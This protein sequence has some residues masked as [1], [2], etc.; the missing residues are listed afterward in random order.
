VPVKVVVVDYGSNPRHL[1]QIRTLTQPDWIRLI[2]VTRDTEPWREG[3]AL[4]IGIKHTE[5]PYLFTTN[6]DL[7]F[8]PNFV[9]LVLGALRQDPNAFVLCQNRIELD[10]AGND[11]GLSD[12][13]Y[14]GSCM[15]AP[16]DWW[17]KVGG[18]D[19]RYSVWGYVDIDVAFRAKTDG[20][21]WHDISGDAKI[22]H[23]YHKHIRF[24][25][26]GVQAAIKHN[27][28]IFYGTRGVVR[29]DGHWGEL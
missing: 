19:E 27:R 10:K 7:I 18:Y 1:R 17:L 4:N 26:D 29:N 8:A 6:A 3:R 28:D 14:Y 22:R 13:C 2:E 15:G 5:T 21:R 9:S 23:Q 24:D 25:R 11:A 20:R 16:K 12:N